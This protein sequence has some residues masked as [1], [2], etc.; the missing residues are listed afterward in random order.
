MLRMSIGGVTLLLL[1]SGL[2]AAEARPGEDEGRRGRPAPGE[3]WRRF[4]DFADR[5]GR[6][7]GFRRPDD[8]GRDDTKTAEDGGRRGRGGPPGFGRGGAGAGRAGESRRPPWARW[9]RDGWRGRGEFGGWSRWRGGVHGWGRHFGERDGRGHAFGRYGHHGHRHHAFH[10]GRGFGPPH[11]G[12]A[13]GGRGGPR[14]HFGPGSRGGFGFGPRGPARREGPPSREAPSRGPAQ[15]AAP[16]RTAP[17]TPSRLDD[18]E[19][20]L[21]RILKDVEELRRDIRR[22]PR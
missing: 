14:A 19:K 8:R 17:A 1:A 2:P 5:G 9:G 6:F 11:R 3:G 15:R 16:S 13:W 4:A 12:H 21:D 18:L 7:G 22:S 10:H 20:R